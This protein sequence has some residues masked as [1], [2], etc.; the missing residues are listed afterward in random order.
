MPVRPP[1]CNRRCTCTRTD[2]PRRRVRRAQL[3]GVG[4]GEQADPGRQL[5]HTHTVGRA[6]IDVDDEPRLLDVERLGAVDIGDRFTDG[7]AWGKG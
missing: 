7:A 1:P 5:H 2:N 6:D 3:R 4:W